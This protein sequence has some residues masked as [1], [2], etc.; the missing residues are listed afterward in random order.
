M[1]IVDIE[2][3]FDVI[4]NEMSRKKIIEVKDRI[5]NKLE[6]NDVVYND[7]IVSHYSLFTVMYKLPVKIIGLSLRQVEMLIDDILTDKYINKYLRGGR[8]SSLEHSDLSYVVVLEKDSDK[9]HIF[10]RE[11]IP[12]TELRNI[13]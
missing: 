11:S 12:E 2:F 13:I 3:D 1:E 4:G 5:K 6:K 8:V 7:I 10:K 9:Y